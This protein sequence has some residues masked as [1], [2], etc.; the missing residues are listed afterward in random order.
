MNSSRPDSS[1][2]EQRNSNP[3]EAGSN[4]ARGSTYERWH[5][6]IVRRELTGG[7]LLA[8]VAH[9]A[10][11]SAAK[12]AASTGADL[13]TDTRAC[14]LVATKEQMAGIPEAVEVLERETDRTFRVAVITETDGPLT[15]S[16]TAIG[17][18]TDGRDFLKP[19]LGHLRPWRA[20]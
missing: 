15:G 3:E 16:T 20:P 5:Y 19:V 1:V 6:I 13:P 18:F 8:Q 14:V 7:A 9:A 12:W 10:G 2:P 4:P 11:E 17:I